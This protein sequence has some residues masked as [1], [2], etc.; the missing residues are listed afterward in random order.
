M[1]KMKVE[2]RPLT[3]LIP[4]KR[5][6]RRNDQA[7]ERV[8]ASLREFGWRQ[9]I[10]VDE[11]GVII[12]G[13]TRYAA[14]LALGWTHAPVHVA[15]GLTPEQVR[16]YRIADNKTAEFATWDP[17]MLAAELAELTPDQQGWTAF[18]PQEV[19]AIEWQAG[20]IDPAPAPE[21]RSGNRDPFE[22]VTFTLHDAQAAVV[23]EAIALAKRI[24]KAETHGNTNSNGN[25]LHSICAAY[26][27]QWKDAAQDAD[28]G[29]DGGQDGGDDGD[30]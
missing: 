28:Q 11:E 27:E 3:A 22:A 29:Q 12:A 5:N 13:H 18:T 23:R 2:Q 17:G 4:Y 10:V 15:I 24:G 7:V 9:P 16:A 6:P 14:A 30:G 20:S 1:Q 25:A 26:L 21:V 8:A 19:Q